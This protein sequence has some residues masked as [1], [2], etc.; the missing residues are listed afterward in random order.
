MLKYWWLPLFA[1]VFVHGLIIA[2][3]L[4]S[5]TGRPEVVMKPPPKFVKAELVTLDKPKAKPAPT[6]PAKKPAPA[7]VPDKKRE[8][9]QRQ[10]KL[11]QEKKRQQELAQKKAKEEKLAAEK[12]QKEA[13]ER[14]RQEEAK[15][16]AEQERER[17]RLLREAEQEM[18]QMLE[19]ERQ[20][21][22]V[23]EDE[24]LANSYTALISQA[25]QSQWS[26]PPS[27]RNDMEVELELRLV[28]TGEVVNVRVIKSSGNAAFD[29]SAESAVRRVGQFPE[30]QKV[31][32]RVF[33]KYF[34]QFKLR[35]RPEDLRL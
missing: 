22:Q 15:R 26:R 8:E 31:P 24:E 11:Q 19:S 12:R 34:R 27:A 35:F 33:E 25:I 2:V 29:R 32:N 5:V 17:D 9:Q 6:P 10:Q 3:L 16:Q 23:G 28:P 4:L 18:A 13:A 21:Q 7:P 20:A 14:K 1:T 30:L